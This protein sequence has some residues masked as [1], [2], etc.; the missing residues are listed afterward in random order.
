LWR[1]SI[2][3][4]A[5]AFLERPIVLFGGTG[6]IGRELRLQ[7]GAWWP[8]L[9]PHRDEVNLAR[10]EGVTTYLRLARPAL[11]VNA[12][13]F[14]DIDAAET[15]VT[16]AMTVNG[17][18]PLMLAEEA[19]DRNIGLVHFS[20]D[21]VFDGRRGAD[22][23]PYREADAPNP[24]N[25]YGRSMLRGESAIGYTDPPH[26]IF[27]TSRVFGLRGSN[28]LIDL[29]ALA[30]AHEDINVVDDQIGS[31]T[32]SRAIAVAVNSILKDLDAPRSP[33]AMRE[34]S[35][36]YHL[37]GAGAVSW[38]GFAVLTLPQAA[39]SPYVDLTSDRQPVL[40]AISSDSYPFR[41]A[42][43]I[44]TALSSRSVVDAF[45]IELPPW[46]Q[47]LESCLRAQPG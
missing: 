31:P 42:R 30:G 17:H 32:W 45:G 25:V 13:A 11:I 26:L 1:F 9:A 7:L 23:A 21:L 2:N 22:P 35:G 20:T 33:V 24:L 34:R 14:T 47:Q 43:P 46:Q 10:P 44:Y 38:Y 29:V 36:I 27:R 18:I 41:A 3:Q 40:H 16:T 4:H 6:Q 19:S 8:V 39:S 37:A 15:D 28:F 12:A 5:E